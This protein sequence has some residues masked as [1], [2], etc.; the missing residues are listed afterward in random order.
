MAFLIR[1]GVRL[2]Y[3][4]TGAGPPLV[5]HHGFAGS[6][7]AWRYFGF[8]QQLK[9]HYQL[10]MPDARGHGLSGKPHDVRA[11]SMSERIDDVLAILDE[12]KIERAHFFGYSM[13]GLVA[14]G[15]ARR[16]QHRLR[17][18]IIGSAHPYE[19]HSWDVFANVDGSNPAAFIAALET[20]LNEHLSDEVKAAVLSNDLWALSAAAKRKRPSLE[21]VLPAI[22]IPCLLYCGEADARHAAVERCAAALPAGS[23]VSLPGAGHFAGMMRSD[24][25]LPHVLPFLAEQERNA[26]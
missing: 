15:L 3:Q 10:I 23:F 6:W 7:S 26:G 11:Y 9:A 19:D 20:A 21:H 8:V 18:L 12:L 24:L 1:D 14:Y 4:T 22:S 5:L 17:S 13:G 25:V 2:H 16:A